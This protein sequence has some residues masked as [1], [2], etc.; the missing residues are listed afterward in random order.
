MVLK[1]GREQQPHTTLVGWL[2]T[3]WPIRSTWL[4]N[5]CPFTSRP[6]RFVLLLAH[7]KTGV[8]L[9]LGGLGSAHSPPEILLCCWVFEIADHHQHR[10][11][12]PSWR[13]Q[14]PHYP[15]SHHPNPKAPVL[16]LRTT[17]RM[18]ARFQ[19]TR[20]LRRMLGGP[21]HTVSG[22]ADSCRRT[23]RTKA[24]ATTVIQHTGA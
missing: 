14:S 8:V 20:R 4:T 7:L 22:S 24:S 12:G 11:I 1:P 19:S 21:A 15:Q 16:S 3:L 17:M 6:A 9:S 2:R 18:L 10:A 23:Q 13:P 5:P